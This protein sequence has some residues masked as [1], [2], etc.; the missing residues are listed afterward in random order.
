MRGVMWAAI[1]AGAVVV[2]AVLTVV[3]LVSGP[4]QTEEL[5]VSGQHGGDVLSACARV[6]LTAPVTYAVS[7]PVLDVWGLVSVDSVTITDP[8]LAAHTVE[9]CDLGT[10][11]IQ[12]RAYVIHPECN[13]PWEPEDPAFAVDV[14]CDGRAIIY[15]GGQ[16]S[17]D[18]TLVIESTETLPGSGLARGE[19]CLG[20]AFELQL[21]GPS[22][23]V[24]SLDADQGDL[25]LDLQ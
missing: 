2:A 24:A 11:G 23:L 12:A 18:W 10:T 4:Q 3:P 1:A 15:S 5:S 25:C 21:D 6:T 7:R 19:W 16:E 17:T 22:G 8:T 13:G 14:I 20:S 9:G